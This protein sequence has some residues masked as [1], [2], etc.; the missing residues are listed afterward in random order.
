MEVG[1]DQCSKI[2]T[3]DP[4]ANRLVVPFRDAMS[5]NKFALNLE[6]VFRGARLPTSVPLT[7]NEV[8][9]AAL[10]VFVGYVTF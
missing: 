9:V 1:D 8:L 7:Y 3:V 2:L 6:E 4:E 5:N 10:E